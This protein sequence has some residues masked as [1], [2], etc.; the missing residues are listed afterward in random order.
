MAAPP[1]PSRRA[2]STF[3]TS[4]LLPFA[5]EAVFGA[6]SDADLLA[7]WW[8]PSGFTN[9]FE[10]FEFEPGGRWIFVMKSP[11]GS[12]H[13]NESTFREIIAPP[14]VVIEHLST[15]RFIL[16]VTLAPAEAGSRVEWEQEFESAA[17]AASLKHIVE[18][19][20][21]QNLDRLEAVLGDAG[22]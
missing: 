5:P 16:T 19:A 22:A 6:F 9:R 11:N 7:R 15:P 3:R 21:E 2:D 4:R 13:P 10:R 20:N 1:A 17:V 14:R 12:I 8:G 18:P